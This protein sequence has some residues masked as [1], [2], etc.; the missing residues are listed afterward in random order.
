MKKLYVS[1][2]SR[3]PTGVEQIP[4]TSNSNLTEAYSNN[5]QNR[6]DRKCE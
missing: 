2:N 6:V 3:S 1:D 5:E 4:P